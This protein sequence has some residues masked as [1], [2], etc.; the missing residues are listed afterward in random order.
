MCSHFFIATTM[1]SL[2]GCCTP[3]N[4]SYGALI[5]LTSKL[6]MK[7]NILCIV[8]TFY[9]LFIYMLCKS[10]LLFFYIFQCNAENKYAKG[11]CMHDKLDA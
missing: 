11:K 2:M 10:I 9:F 3:Q 7:L 4:Y 1:N 6:K 8:K 5:Y